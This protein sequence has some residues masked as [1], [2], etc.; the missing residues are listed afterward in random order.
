[1]EV[2]QNQQETHDQIMKSPAKIEKAKTEKGTSESGNAEKKVN[3]LKKKIIRLERKKA[4]LAA[5][6]LTLADV[7]PR[8]VNVQKSLEDYLA[9]TPQNGKHK[10]EVKFQ[11]FTIML[12]NF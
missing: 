4:K 8:H 1:M 2:P 12:N 5:K 11:S 10:L 9:E 3:P 7:K 6:G